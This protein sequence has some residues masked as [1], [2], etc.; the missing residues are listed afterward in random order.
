[1]A[2]NTKKTGAEKIRWNLSDLFSGLDDPKIESVL[3]DAE[4]KADTFVE[5]YRGKLAALTPAELNQAFKDE[6]ALIGPLYRLSQYTSLNTAADTS[7]EVAKAL[8]ARVDEALSKI[9]NKLVFFNLELGA[10]PEKDYAKF[11]GAPELKDFRYPL[12]QTRKNA[13]YNLSEKEEQILNLKNLT[14]MRANQK[15]YDELT[16]SFQFE[17]EL[18]GEIQKLNGSQLR[19]LRVH[20]DK[21]VR[22]RAMRMFFERYADNKLVIS[23]LYNT[24][25]KDFGLEKDLRGYKTPISIMNTHNDLEEEAVHALI[26]VTTESYGLVQRYYK[27]K[28]QL[29]ALDEMTLADIYAPLPQ[30]PQGYN[31][32]DAKS[33]VLDAFGSF[34]GEF[35]S[36]A[37]SMFDEQRVDAPV[38]PTKRGGAF[39]SSSTP[40]LKPYVLL[41]FTGKLRDV[42][43]MAHELG[44]AIHAMLGRNRN[45]ST[46]H[47][48][49][50]L[51]ETASVFSEMVLTDYFLKREKDD[52][53]KQAL[54]TSKLEDIFA[55][56]HRQN[57][58]SRF[59]IAAH[60]RVNQGLQSSKDF[61]ELYQSELKNMFGNAV[62]YPEEY[63]WE[64]TSIPHIFHVPF[65]VYAYNFGNLLVLALYQQYL[66]E[67]DAF[68]PKYKKFLSMGS[69]AKPTEITALV[70]ADI[71]DPEFWR[72]SLRYIE[73][74]ID[75]LE[76]TL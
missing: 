47:A 1:M 41:N 44:H 48:I 27:I 54:L 65:Y 76:A 30:S 72:K 57:M 11:D 38:T 12:Y 35:Q 5:K 75:E 15:L 67:G 66:E 50:P 34:D 6:E 18:D 22:R 55:T 61:C 4:G 46:F 53:V 21:D 37:K 2:T 68:I 51:A 3:S 70:G 17:F 45:L 69:S 43:T 13:R 60:E 62:S 14:S 39:C 49:L 29:L 36:L 24:I 32:D 40:D 26:D 73:H 52:G 74:L 63:Q 20:P 25:V 33:L 64:W 23:H 59:E 42:S 31:F 8:D 10:M 16:S 28:S 19:A 9:S 58:F 7:D 56:S 71:S